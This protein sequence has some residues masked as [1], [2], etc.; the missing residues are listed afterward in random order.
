MPANGDFVTIIN[1][2]SLPLKYQANGR[3]Y[4]L[5]PGKNER[6]FEHVRYAKTQNPLM[7]SA[8]KYTIQ[9]GSLVGHRWEVGGI[10]EG[11]DDIFP[12][13]QS[14][15]KELLDREGDDV[16]EIKTRHVVTRGGA[17]RP[18]TAAEAADAIPAQLVAPAPQN[19]PSP[20]EA[21]PDPLKA[22]LGELLADSKG[23]NKATLA[24]RIAELAEA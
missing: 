24:K 18:P 4:S 12:V 5:K 20:P 19:A 7:G 16:V 2:T 22:Q 6:P 15:S 21:A 1:R 23:M 8:D 9:I 3:I 13:E 11:R 17:Q 14:T 10:E